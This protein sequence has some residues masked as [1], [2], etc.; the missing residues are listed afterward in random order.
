MSVSFT[1]TFQVDRTPEETFDAILDIRHWWFGEIEGSTASLGDEF[2]YRVP[3]IHF[4]RMRVTALV[5][6]I[7]LSWLVVDSRLDFVED[8]E[9]WTGTTVTF[10]LS[11]DRGRTEVRFTHEGLVPERECYDACSNAWSSY[12]HGSLR[13]LIEAQPAA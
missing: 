13:D 6:G 4:S 11:E 1:T 5:P 3:G 10:V 9:E 8:T 7:K 12:L 2:S